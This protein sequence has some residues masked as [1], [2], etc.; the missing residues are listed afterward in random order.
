MDKLKNI[1]KKEEVSEQSPV[2]YTIIEKEGC[3]IMVL[4]IPVK[5]DLIYHSAVHYNNQLL[6]FGGEILYCDTNNVQI[7]DLSTQKYSVADVSGTIPEP[8]SWHTATIDEENQKMLVFGGVPYHDGVAYSLD[9]N[10]MKWNI[11]NDVQY[12][13]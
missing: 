11:I 3:H 1:D 13:R 8:M 2:E 12:E 4:E 9:L 10:D 5:V 7:Y 6:I